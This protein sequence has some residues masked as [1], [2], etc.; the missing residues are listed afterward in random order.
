MLY[1]DTLR[2]RS[3]CHVTLIQLNHIRM[4]LILYLIDDK[5]TNDI[6]CNVFKIVPCFYPNPYTNTAEMST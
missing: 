5:T 2:I 3:K 6:Q 4:T 1:L